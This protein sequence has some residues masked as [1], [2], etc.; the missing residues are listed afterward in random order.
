MGIGEQILF[1]I[2][3]FVLSISE[4]YVVMGIVEYI[5]FSFIY[6]FVF[7]IYEYDVF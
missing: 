3:L 6:L 1:F 2:L 5:L 4:F 7:I